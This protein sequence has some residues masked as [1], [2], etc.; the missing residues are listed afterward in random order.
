MSGL[1]L[2]SPLH[3]WVTSLDEVPD[4]V[5]ADRMMGDGVAIDPLGDALFSPC[6]GEIVSVHRARHAVSM[7]TA[8]GAEILMHIGL[9]TVALQGEGFEAHVR[10]GQRVAVGERLISFDLDGL[11]RQ[12]R[13]LLTPVVV[14][15]PEAFAIVRRAEGRELG[16]DQFLMELRAVDGRPNRG[17]AS[18]EPASRTVRVRHAHGLHARPAALLAAAAKR[19]G[20]A[21]E[22]AF[23]A[24]A[25]KAAG[26]ACR[27]WA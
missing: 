22:I 7:R 23:A 15:N 2:H 20:V 8:N 11:A 6:A 1:I 14:T 10:D 3:G 25:S 9:D 21:I 27:P 5:F 13:S 17:A 18:S 4:P 16:V 12:V 26:R 19:S 24:A